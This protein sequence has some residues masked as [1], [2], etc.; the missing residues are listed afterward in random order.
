MQF[1]LT[2]GAEDALDGIEPS[3]VAD[4]FGRRLMFATRT[5]GSSPRLDVLQAVGDTWVEVARDAI[6]RGSGG[7]RDGVE[8]A[9]V[10][11]DA[12]VASLFYGARD[13]AGV[14]TIHRAT[15]SDG[16]MWT[17]EG[18]APVPLEGSFDAFGQVPHSVESTSD[19]F[20]LWY[21][22]F[23]G[24]TWRIGA[25]TAPSLDGPWTLEPGDFD[26]WQLGTGFPGG[27]DDSGVR[28]PLVLVDGDMRHLFYSA[29]DGEI[30]HVGHA[31]AIG[32]GRDW[33]RRTDPI[34]DL[35]L[36]ALSGTLGS[37][38]AA[39][40]RSPVA[41]EEP[42]GSFSAWYAGYDGTTDRV[43]RAVPMVGRA[44]GLFEDIWY[45]APR[46]PTAGDLLTFTTERGDAE[47]SVVELAQVTED[48]VTSGTGMSSLAI[49][50]ARGLLYVTSKLD[51]FVT[52]VDTR[53]DGD[54]SFVDSN[55]HD[56][57]GLLRIES[58]SG[59]TG[60]R[61]VLLAPQHGWLLLLSNAPDAVVVLDA[62]AV[63]DDAQKT[64]EWGVPIGTLALPAAFEDAGERTFSAIGG[65]GMA[66][67]PDGSLLLVAHFR[68]N[69]VHAFD[70]TV[71]AVGREVAVIPYVGE[72]PHVVRFAPDGRTAVV[73]NY[74]G[75]VF[76]DRVESTLMIVD[77][78]PSS[79][80]FL[81][82][83]TW[84]ANR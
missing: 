22:G 36:P 65:A 66:L 46:F 69:S 84:I 54:G 76:D 47:V 35:T 39:G 9:A 64:V 58:F 32:D 48:F 15:S 44:T 41:L 71:D 73:A 80:T 70:L 75:D 24:S 19:G 20:R 45:P 23:D 62:D 50:D 43:G 8:G 61:D 7:N 72:N 21:S 51:D 37:F 6:P 38:S 28:D 14:P 55:H 79:P 53:D 10:A 29:F 2:Q 83:L 27:V 68:G 16:T 17:T 12:G 67:S 26:A 33:D 59:A 52:V 77:T 13:G 1:T 5:D 31:V 78:D 42:D 11:V 34:A 63:T 56:V 3:A 4:L 30:W 40:V 82:P 57:E 81:E 60:Y 74:L 25:A 18:G 49:D